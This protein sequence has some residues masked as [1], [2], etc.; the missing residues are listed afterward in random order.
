[1]ADEHNIKELQDQYPYIPI[2]T[3]DE[4]DIVGEALG[5]NLVHSAF[6]SR[7]YWDYLDKNLQM[8]PGRAD[9]NE[10][11]FYLNHM[12]GRLLAFSDND[13]YLK[14][15]LWV[16]NELDNTPEA[17]LL[18]IFKAHQDGCFVK[19]GLINAIDPNVGGRWNEETKAAASLIIFG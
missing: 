15:W 10:W 6:I 3:Q 5:Y 18:R 12:E 4:A 8:K 9:E 14:I 17:Q 19:Q 16:E 7:R 1:M 11:Y 13:D 2:K